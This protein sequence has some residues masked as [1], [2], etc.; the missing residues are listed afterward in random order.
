M[1]GSTSARSSSSKVGSLSASALR[2]APGRHTRPASTSPA[3]IKEKAD[4][5]LDAPYAP[6]CRQ[7]RTAYLS[8]HYPI[9]NTPARQLYTSTGGR[10]PRSGDGGVDG[11]IKEDRLGLD[12][13]CASSEAS[14]A[15]VRHDAGI[16]PSDNRICAAFSA[17]GDPDRWQRS[18]GPDDRARSSRAGEQDGFLQ[19]AGR[20]FFQ[21]IC[22]KSR[23]HSTLDMIRNSDDGDIVW[24]VVSSGSATSIGT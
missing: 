9:R 12:R 8:D 5:Q 14:S 2:P 6:L 16:Q 3:R 15:S 1:S 19:E 23:R 17:T 4:L 13:V 18:C 22:V 21:R 24:H 10:A 20:R 11:V 7:N